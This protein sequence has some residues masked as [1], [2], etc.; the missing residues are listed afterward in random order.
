MGL[1]L[2][3]NREGQ[4]RRM[5]YAT[6][7][8]DDKLTSRSLDIPVRGSIPLDANGRF[9]LQIVGDAAFEKS[10][11]AAQ[12]ALQSI[13]EKSKDDPA[14]LQKIAYNKATGRKL[15]EVYLDD[16][17]QLWRELPKRRNTSEDWLKVADSFF[18]RFAAFAKTQMSGKHGKPCT[19]LNLVTPEIA[20]SYFALLEKEY[21]HETVKKQIRLLSS[22]YDLWATSGCPNPFAGF[23]SRND[24]SDEIPHEPFSRSQLNR[25]L[26]LAA[27]D[28][29]IYPLAVTAAF[30]G[31]RLGDVCNLQW[32][33]VNLDIG[34][35]SV[36]TSKA[37]I[38]ANIPILDMRLEEV[39]KRQIPASGRLAGPV[40]PSATR[41]YATKRD[42]ITKAI[43]PFIARALFEKELAT[44]PAQLENEVRKPLNLEQ[45]RK[46]VC[47]A[48][49]PA[50]RRERILDTY[51]R[52][53]S[54]ETYSKIQAATN[55]AR[56]VISSDLQ[57]VEALT[58][59]TI[60]PRKALSGK[61]KI[62]L[63]KMTQQSRLKGSH[64]ASL[65]GWHSF[66]T[67]FVTLAIEA[68]L[69][70]TD[71]GQIVGHTTTKMTLRYYK[72]RLKNFADSIRNKL[73]A[74]AAPQSPD[75]A[76]A[77]QSILASTDLTPEAKN[78]AILALSTKQIAQPNP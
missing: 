69:S 58:G 78:A 22:A 16:L 68:G 15:T 14:H 72:P 76:T 6:L 25:I 21:S 67:T 9:S 57:T 53:K 12:D 45:V 28:P 48:N 74:S 64:A 54:G 19:K 35:I 43:K 50:N 18:S 34:L 62:D 36:V 46:I 75:L 2:T 39:L 60:R 71:I 40:F 23:F 1:K 11:R 24:K 66:R 61:A 4:Y 44:T 56:S 10:K 37:K 31:M 52:F 3:K 13:I 65:Y 41:L 17:S 77:I 55:R 32:E 63:L 20:Q 33:N 59:E 51:T 5:W 26:E 42:Q 70:P 27:E 38:L 7:W 73:R 49:L 29:T 47:A 30:T 8:I